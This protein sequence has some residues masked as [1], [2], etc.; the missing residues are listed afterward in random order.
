MCSLVIQR[1]ARTSGQNKP[2]CK[3]GVHG[4]YFF[5]LQSFTLFNHRNDS[6]IVLLLHLNKAKFT[7]QK[8]Q[9]T[10]CWTKLNRR[11][12]NYTKILLHTSIYFYDIWHQC[13]KVKV[14]F[15]GNLDPSN[16]TLIICIESYVIYG[17]NCHF[18][19]VKFE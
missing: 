4:P 18:L 17:T 1:Q 11:I 10:P 19:F 2:Q 7:I 15:L 13:F 12:L 9:C 16:L 5:F 14:I 8:E 6:K 3:H